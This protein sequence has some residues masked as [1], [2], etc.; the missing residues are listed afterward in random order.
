MRVSCVWHRSRKVLWWKAP[1]VAL[2]GRD[3]Q[4][5][6]QECVYPPAIQG[7]N[8]STP[9]QSLRPC[10][11][12][13]GTC[14]RCDS[15]SGIWYFE[16]W[17]DP[18]DL[19]SWPVGDGNDSHLRNRRT[20]ARDLRNFCPTTWVREGGIKGLDYSDAPTSAHQKSGELPK[21]FWWVPDLQ[22]TVSQPHMRASLG[23]S[24]SLTTWFHIFS[25]VPSNLVP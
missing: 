4:K 17:Q 25:F 21:K 24:L 3:H 6:E 16:W 9:D 15:K 7:L 11:V 12:I 14:G 5:Q 1:E 20:D 22:P 13:L 10:K 19:Q 18:L 23:S 2:T 8:C